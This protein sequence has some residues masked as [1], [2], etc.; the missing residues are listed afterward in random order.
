MHVA[1]GQYRRRW[2]W[3]TRRIPPRLKWAVRRSGTEMT[4]KMRGSRDTAGRAVSV[5]CCIATALLLAG[6][7]REPAVVKIGVGQPLSGN[8]GALGQD[9][10]NGAKMAIDEINAKGGVRIGANRATLELVTA[11]DKADA[12][13]GESAAQQ[14]VDSGITVA[15]AHLN[16]GVSIAAAP[17]Y[18]RAG[19]PQLAI[20]TKPTYT[21]QGLPTTL[22]LVANDNLQARAMG[23]Y[24]AQLAGAQRFAVADDG[25]PYGKGLA[26]DAAGEIG[27]QKREV[28]LR[29][30]F[31]DKRTDFAAFVAEMKKANVD[32]LVTTLNDYQVEALIKQ[33]HAAGM[34]R[35]RILGGDTI[36]TDKLAKVAGQ[37]AAIYATS[38]IVEAREFPNGKP[39]LDGFRQRFKG[40]PV[41]GAHYAYDA[42]YL[43]ADA[44]SR[45]D[46]AD[47]AKLLERLK[48][49]GFDG[50]APV[51]GSM[52]FATDGEQRYSAVAVYLLRDGAWLPQIRSDRW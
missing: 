23:S 42:V 2:L 14:L 13:A 48:N 4:S 15:L 32:V 47:R 49:P 29:Q 21:Q 26:D 8:L 43:V 19:V 51:T 35:L 36:K 30:S 11:D 45:N 16:S 44:I 3:R 25:T 5:L 9:M 46:T 10:V 52:R 22:R 7:S 24:A 34:A 31:D 28:A 38:P 18:A 20:S 12:K 40:E 39:F 41:Y 1:F 17:V 37:V 6:C 27:K 33:A 50:N